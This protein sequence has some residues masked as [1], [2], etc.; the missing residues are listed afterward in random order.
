MP[1]TQEDEAELFVTTTDIDGRT[2]SVTVHVDFDGI[3]HVGHLLF[4]DAEWEEDEGVRDFG[5][6]PGRTPSDIQ[7]AA[8][9]LTNHD[10]TLPSKRT[11]FRLK[12][13]FDPAD[14]ASSTGSPYSRCAVCAS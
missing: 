5:T 11:A 2:F 14:P 8:R 1:T 7:Q 13:F 10:L 4:R 9:A 3:E 12:L 6:I